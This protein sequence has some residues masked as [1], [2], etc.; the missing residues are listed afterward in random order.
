MQVLRN[1]DLP[2]SYVRD[3]GAKIPFEDLVVPQIGPFK[4]PGTAGNT[5][6][7]SPYCCLRI[8]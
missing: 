7:I 8:F 3:S 2:V 6:Q 5:K 4:L 1:S